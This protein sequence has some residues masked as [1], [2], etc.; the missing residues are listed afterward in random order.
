MI[1]TNSM[2]EFVLNYAGMHAA[3]SWNHIDW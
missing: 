2:E 3:I 1:E